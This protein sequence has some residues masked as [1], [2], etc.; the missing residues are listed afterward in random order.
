ME[1]AL[2]QERLELKQC[3]I[4][5]EKKKR[6]KVSKGEAVAQK[7]E[8]E[9]NIER[10]PFRIRRYEKQNNNGEKKQIRSEIKR[11]KVNE[12]VKK[13]QKLLREQKMMEIRKMIENGELTVEALKWKVGK[14]EADQKVENVEVVA[15]ITTEAYSQNSKVNSNLP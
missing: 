6:R 7:E 15:A 9:S 14:G 2:S 1:Q 10:M 4:I 8:V 3:G 11:V 5:K 13:R 12:R